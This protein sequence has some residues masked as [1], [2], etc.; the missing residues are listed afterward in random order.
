MSNKAKG[1]PRKVPDPHL[2]DQFII[3]DLEMKRAH[4]FGIDS[5]MAQQI[6]D[7]SLGLEFEDFG[8]RSFTPTGI[9]RDEMQTVRYAD[10]TQ[11][12]AVL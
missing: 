10:H 6:R 2:V 8:I 9:Q 7:R 3:V 11:I 5:S 1:R 12:Q 4:E